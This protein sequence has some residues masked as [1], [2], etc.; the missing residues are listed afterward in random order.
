MTTACGPKDHVV[1]TVSL[2]TDHT[3]NT[4]EKSLHIHNDAELAG[5]V[6][7]LCYI[8]ANAIFCASKSKD[9]QQLYFQVAT[10][11]VE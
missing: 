9:D 3:H 4:Q 8:V 1:V 5:A 10:V 2:T 11:V 7:L 6:R